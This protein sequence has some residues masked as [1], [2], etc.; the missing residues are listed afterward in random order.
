MQMD[1]QFANHFSH[2]ILILKSGHQF[3]IHICHAETKIYSS[4]FCQKYT[5]GE[6][7]FCLFLVVVVFFNLFLNFCKII[8]K[9]DQFPIGIVGRY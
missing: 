2:F 3:H 6:V 8:N 4:D 7:L 1:V 5:G 9:Q